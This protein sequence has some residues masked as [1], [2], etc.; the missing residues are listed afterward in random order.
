[1]NI[2]TYCSQKHMVTDPF[3]FN[4]MPLILTLLGATDSF[5]KSLQQEIP[6][7]KISKLFFKN[8]L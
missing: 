4:K 2:Q 7:L 1:M 6:R 3:V 8:T 5:L